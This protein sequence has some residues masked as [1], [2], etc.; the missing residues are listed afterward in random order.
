MGKSLEEERVGEGK[1]EERT[2]EAKTELDK[3]EVNA[4]GKMRGRRGRKLNHR[5][6]EE[7]EKGIK[8]TK[9]KRDLPRG[10][11]SG[12]EGWSKG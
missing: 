9:E 6:E 4:T 7:K 2:L 1:R 10:R 5:G 3:Q 8:G 11:R 12:K